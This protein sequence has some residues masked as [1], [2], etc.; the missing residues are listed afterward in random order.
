MSTDPDP[1]PTIM[2]MFAEH[3]ALT[4]MTLGQEH[5]TLWRILSRDPDEEAEYTGTLIRETAQ[6][7]EVIVDG[8]TEATTFPKGTNRGITLWRR[9]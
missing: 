7:F 5:V 3:A 8:D 2:S 6:I 9:A 4:A 1:M